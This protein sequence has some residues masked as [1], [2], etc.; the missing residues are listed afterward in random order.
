MTTSLIAARFAGYFDRRQICL[1]EEALSTRQRG[2]IRSHGWSIQYLFGADQEG[3][4]L[5][6][7][8]NHRMTNARHE[9]IYASGAM[10]RLPTYEEFIV[11]PA[12]ATQ[13]ER[14]KID[15]AYQSHNAAV[16]E[17]LRQKGFV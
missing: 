15:E 1:P 7:F 2:E 5:D 11:Y 3:E 9:R 8:A 13:E 14:E 4:Y 12:H 10:Q 6:F 17:L 16:S